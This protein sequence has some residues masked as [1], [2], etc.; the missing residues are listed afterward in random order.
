MKSVN[1]VF[2]VTHIIFLLS[3]LFMIIGCGGGDGKSGNTAQIPANWHSRSMLGGGKVTFTNGTFIALGGAIIATSPDGTT[4]TSRSVGAYGD[5]FFGAAYGNDTFVVVGYTYSPPMGVIPINTRIFHS[6][7]GVEWTSINSSLHYILNAVT[8][9]NGLFVAVGG[10]GVILTSP[11]GREWTVR[12]SGINAYLYDVTYSD[13]TFVAVGEAG[14]I[15]T[16]SNGKTWTSGYSGLTEAYLHGVVYG[17]GTYVA[18]GNDIDSSVVILTSLDGAKWTARVSG[19]AN[20]TDLIGVAFGKGIFVAAGNDYSGSTSFF[21]SSDG[22]MWKKSS[23]PE[24]GLSGIT[25]G[26][27]TFVVTGFDYGTS[28]SVILQSDPVR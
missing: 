19:M 4:W 23:G 25:Y 22:T 26:N 7:D 14:T 1:R 27:D 21:T 12:N 18:V 10:L 16:S 15:I 5:N 6:A 9:G 20:N 17:N 28:Q 24:M 11:D 3:S 8:Y 13:G 2:N